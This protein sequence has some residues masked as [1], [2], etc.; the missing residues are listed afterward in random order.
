[1]QA[2]RLRR[3]EGKQGREGRGPHQL[4]TNMEKT[5]AVQAVSLSVLDGMHQRLRVVDDQAM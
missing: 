5:I 4:Q 2:R 1:V 3:K